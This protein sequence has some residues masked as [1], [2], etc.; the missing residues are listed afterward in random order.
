[1]LARYLPE[2]SVAGYQGGG[3]IFEFVVEG[4]I[5]EECQVVAKL[6]AEPILDRPDR[7][8]KVLQFGVADEVT[9]PS[10][11]QWIT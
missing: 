10:C 8:D 6:S 7:L 2:V 11:G 4:L 3:D 5:V 1:M 9:R